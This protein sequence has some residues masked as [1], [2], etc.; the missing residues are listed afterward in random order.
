MAGATAEPPDLTPRLATFRPLSRPAQLT[1]GL[2]V[3]AL[4]VYL[5]ALRT[6]YGYDGQMM[7]RVTE[8]L[9]VRQSFQVV[10][11]VWHM[12]EPYTFYG[13]AVSLLLL[14]VFLLGQVL[15]HDGSRLIVLYE[16]TI[17]ALTVVAVYRLA[18]E[19]GA[20]YVRSLAA[21]LAFAFGTLAWYYST[22][23][24]TE[25]LIGLAMIG[26]LWSLYRYRRDGH[27]RELLGAGALVALTLLARWDSVLLVIVPFGGY[28]LIQVRGRVL[29]G[30]KWIG[31]LLLFAAPIAA[32]LAVNLA[33][34]WVRYGS[35]L[36]AGPRTQ[37]GGAF[38]TP[39]LTG[40]YGL[41][42]SPGASIVMYVPLVLA[43]A[44]S[45]PAFLRRWRAE[46][47]LITALLVLRLLVYAQWS[48]WD[49]REWGPRFLVPVL[50]LLVLMLIA[51]PADRRIRIGAVVLIGLGVSI[52]LLG[53]IVPYDTIVWPQTAP[54]IVSTLG[55]HDAA[56]SSCLCSW[57]VDRAAATA[58]DFDP[59]FSPLVR[60]VILLRQGTIDPEWQAFWPVLTALLGL[61][62]AGILLLWRTARRLDTE[63]G[64]K[65]WSLR[66][67]RMA[68]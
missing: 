61:A 45:F 67:S 65:T 50:P 64:A 28:A 33:Y 36:D 56:G 55:L 32:A 40:L 54:L 18:R 41:L 49:G 60:Q 30:T 38:S 24:F 37:G 58:M 59:R 12:N 21:A 39:L 47:L 27:A 31:R 17:S 66:E 16:P 3:L 57:V 9:A 14:P 7:Y 8:S 13:L 52:Q 51:L 42:L 22:T 1:L 44:A 35:P 26:A 19:L 6:N 62:A 34:D 11:P 10:D 25:P 53:Q 29:P 15:Q 2:F 48:F 5:L 23:V 63:A 4:G 43:V 46:A 68:G 20:S